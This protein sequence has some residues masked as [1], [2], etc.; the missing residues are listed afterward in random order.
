MTEAAEAQVAAAPRKDRSLLWWVLS[1]L[2]GLYMAEFNFEWTLRALHIQPG[3][4]QLGMSRQLNETSPPGF[5]EVVAVLPAGPAERAGIQVG[6]H[7]GFMRSGGI[8]RQ[9]AVGEAAPIIHERDGVRRELTLIADERPFGI[10]HMEWPAFLGVMALNVSIVMGLVIIARSR[11][12]VS[13]LW[14]GVALVV[15]GGNSIWPT[16]WTSWFPLFWFIAA[17][18]WF[19]YALLPIALL[20]FAMHFYR[21]NVGPLRASTRATF[22]VYAAAVLLS[23]ALMFLTSATSTWLPVVGGGRILSSTIVYAGLIAAGWLLFLGWRRSASDVQQR[24]AIMLLGIGLILIS[25]ALQTTFFF[26]IPSVNSAWGAGLGVDISTWLS[27]VFAPA[28][29]AYAMLRHRVFDLGFA[30]NRTLIFSVV[31]AILLLAFGLAEWV[32]NERLGIAALRDNPLVAAAIAL[33]LFLTFHNIHGAVERVVESVFFRSW[34]EKEAALKRFMREAGFVLKSDVLQRDFLAAIRRFTDNAAVALYQRDD[35][36]AYVRVEGGVAG[37][38]EMIDA[39]E[40]AVV[41]LRADRALVEIVE[42]RS[43]LP[44]VLALPMTIRHEIDGFVL[45]AAKPSGLAYRP[46]EKDELAK[47]TEAIGDDLHALKVEQLQR[48]IANLEARNDELRAALN[49]IQA[50]KPA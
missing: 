31:S 18:Q 17:F 22:F 14:L 39:D 23:M 25:Q 16:F 43:A 34:R 27:G 20:Q 44:A 38:P 10:E 7:V 30:V 41:A 9:V 28:L 36:G 11:R 26:L 42:T 5:M 21:E 4:G 46:D 37:A 47:A 19:T 48:G 15:F 50:P 49:G 45:L 24:Y 40:P 6:D 13:A 2:L 3:V 33:V 29:L 32:V 12:K 1:L 8:N 35:S